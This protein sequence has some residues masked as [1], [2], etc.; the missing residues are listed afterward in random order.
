MF[1]KQI[2]VSTL[3]L[4]S[5]L[6]LSSCSETELLYPLDGAIPQ[7][8]IVFMPDADPRHLKYDSK[9]LGFISAD[10]S[11]RQV[12]TFKLIGGALSNFGRHMP[13]QYASHPRWSM[14]GDEIV[15]SIRSLPPNIRLIDENGRMYGQKCDDIEAGDLAL[16]LAGNALI[17]IHKQDKVYEEYLDLTST[18]LI[19]R[20]N[21][22]ACRVVSVFNVPVPF[23]YLH[24]SIQE[25]EN[26]LLTAPFWD[27]GEQMDNILL[28]NLNTD[29]SQTFPGYHPS[30]TRDG[31]LLAYYDYSGAL[32]VRDLRTE[33]EKTLIL[34]SVDFRDDLVSTPSWS[35]DDQ[36]LVYNTS[37][38]DIFKINIETGEQVYLT[39]GWAPDWR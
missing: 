15:F 27:E 36:W 39:Y 31:S 19:A 34:S 35:P 33:A 28:F 21:I 22:R 8:E 13:T 30:L 14:A 1:T 10:G 3:W 4:I 37:E 5:L 6:V 38:G 16:D 29:E 25:A 11:N 20:Y 17:Q 32:I 2:L 23:G 26:G 24:S 7:S 12:Y 9:T 18:A